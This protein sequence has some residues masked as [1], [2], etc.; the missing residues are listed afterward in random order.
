M[1]PIEIA[2]KK[3]HPGPLDPLVIAEIGV[4]FYDI[5]EQRGISLIDAAKLMLKEAIEAGADMA[6]FQ[7]YKSNTLAAKNS[8]AYWDTTKETTTSQYQLF[9]KFDHFG[10]ADYRELARYSESLGAPFLSTPFDLEAVDYLV[11]LMPAYKVASADIANIPLLNRIA[12]KGK[13]ILLS[14][15]ASSTA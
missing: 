6:K 1:I 13:P 3:I 4:N 10:A 5:A 9:Q 2:G 11:D 15:G 12:S 14:I 8:P 7:S